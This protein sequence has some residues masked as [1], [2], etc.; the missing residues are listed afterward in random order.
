MASWVG[1]ANNNTI[2]W[3]SHVI[4][5]NE[6]GHFMS[7][8]DGNDDITGGDKNLIGGAY[9]GSTLDG[10]A[11][12]DILRAQAGD[13]VLLGGTGNDALL[14]GS[15]ADLLLGGAGDDELV[16]GFGNND[17]MAGGTGD[18]TYY[19][20]LGDDG[21]GDIVNDDMSATWTPGSGGG[22]NDRIELLNTTLDGVIVARAG[23]DLLLSRYEDFLD[24][25]QVN[26]YV[27][28]EDF[29]VHGQGFIEEIGLQDTIIAG[30]DL[31]SIVPNDGNLYFLT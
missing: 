12:D 29:F 25:G 4:A 31:L 8:L 9:I 22:A 2:D 14:G 27:T 6:S 15:G 11:G 1:N 7:G 5:F 13:D 10:G 18:D 26:S 21:R 19:F 3:S 28:V 30:V 16:G 20:T 17:R 23:D 24:D